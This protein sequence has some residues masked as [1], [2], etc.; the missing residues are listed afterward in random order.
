MSG[1]ERRLKKL[2]EDTGQGEPCPECGHVAG[3][4]T[5]DTLD[6]EVYWDYTAE[7]ESEDEFCSTCGTQLV[8]NVTWGAEG[9]ERFHSY[10]PKLRLIEEGEGYSY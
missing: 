5:T 9:K 3:K 7:E 2:E 8:F 6:F 10:E 4:P 1:L